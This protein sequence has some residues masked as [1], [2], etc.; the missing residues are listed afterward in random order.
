MK[1]IT[2]NFIIVTIIGI[3]IIFPNP[4]YSQQTWG[5][6]DVV[7]P[8]SNVSSSSVLCTPSS[9]SWLNK[10]SKVITY[11][12][13]SNSPSKIIGMNFIVI[14]DDL[15]N[16]NFQNNTIDIDRLNLFYNYMNNVYRDNGQ[17]SDGVNGVV[18]LTKKYVEFEL[19]GIYFYRN[20]TLNT[21]INGSNLLAYLTQ[22]DPNR[23]NYLNVFLTNG[24]GY[25][26]ATRG[27][28]YNTN[29]NLFANLRGI[30]SASPLSDYAAA[31]LMAHEMGHT[32]DLCHTY[33]GGGCASTLAAMGT[34]PE[35]GDFFDDVFGPYPG[36]APHYRPNEPPIYPAWDYDVTLSQTDKITNNLLGGFKAEY[37][38]S[39]LQIAK[40]HRALTFKTIRRYL[41]NCVYDVN[42]P[43]EI[44]TSEDWDFDILWDK[45]IV[46]Q[47]S[48]TV[49]LTCKLSMPQTSSIIVESGGILNIDGIVTNNCYNGWNGTIHVKA[50]GILNLK[51]NANITFIGNGKI[52]IDDDVTNPGLLTIEGIPKVYLN[53]NNTMMDIRGMVDI[54]NNSTFTFFPQNNSSSHG[55]IK[56]ANTSLTTSRNIT[57][58][59]NSNIHFTG[60]SQ[61]KKVIQID[62]ET[63]YAPA[64]IV[65][66]IISTGKIEL[67]SDSRIQADGLATNINFYNVKFTSTTQGVNNAHRG[68]HLY[69]QPNI[70]I[71]SCTF[72]NGRTGIF[73]SLSSGAASLTLSQCIFRNNRY[74]ILASDKG[75][76]LIQCYFYDNTIGLEAKFMTFPSYALNGT[77]KGNSKGINFRGYS[78]A[79][80]YAE[81]PNILGNGKGLEIEGVILRTRCGSV[82]FN[83]TGFN[84]LRSSTLIMDQSF[85][86]NTIAAG[87]TAL[88]NN[89]TIQTFTTRNLFLDNGKN[90]LTPLSS[91][92]E[93][94]INGSLYVHSPASIVANANKWNISGSL[95][96]SDYNLRDFH[97][98]PINID[99][100]NPLSST[101]ACGQAIDQCPN[102]PCDIESITDYEY[103]ELLSA[104][105]EGFVLKEE[106]ETELQEFN[107]LEN[108]D[109]LTGEI[110]Q[111]RLLNY[112]I[113]L[114]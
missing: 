114:I 65:N 46:I 48:A 12:P 85:S 4:I 72:E 41:I 96:A 98:N 84:M 43:W 9:S 106:L 45:D 5:C 80:F 99:D 19:K 52:L 26:Q 104:G 91:G 66:F 64:S 17:P 30:Y 95:N 92:T 1:A 16:N 15:G 18:E 83:E 82:S 90:D 2:N 86:Q 44:T 112:F 53:G 22:V 75:I 36:N 67:A 23:L 31:T 32:L 105:F 94:T 58:G 35:D 29:L 11:L 69:G 8:I 6:S 100:P 73:A 14:Q 79:S 71:E 62:Q 110:L 54:K 108:T 50:G 39:P 55:Y 61:S 20:T 113:P 107:N 38:L 78:S 89:T 97:G 68:L 87:V 111:C 40:M 74:G 24:S 42:N 7:S 51:A 103:E 25:A 81:D 101:S 21:S 70:L 10:Y 34:N 60:T 27:S 77:T 56:F 33:L 63:F 3:L 59:S 93:S 76:N 28:S 47:N 57:A 13:I 109:L 49:N 102:P 88:S 37:Y